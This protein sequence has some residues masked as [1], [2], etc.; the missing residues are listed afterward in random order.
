MMKT[1]TALWGIQGRLSAGFAVMAAS[2]LSATDASAQASAGKIA[3][4][5]TGNVQSIGNLLLSGSFLA[6]VGF[7][8]AGLLKVKK[9]ADSDGRDPYGPG[10]WRLGV[11]GALVGLPALTAAMRGTLFGTGTDTVAASTMT[12][13]TVGSSGTGAGGN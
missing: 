13:S 11:G 2:L 1:I 8:G 3:N 5:V 10:L 4:T 9:A 6:G 12:F 7:A